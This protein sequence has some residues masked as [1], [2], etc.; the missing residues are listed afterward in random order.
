MNPL[1]ID[2][3]KEALPN[4]VN[5]VVNQQLVDRI[6]KTLTDP[7]MR[8]RYRE[9]LIS[10]ASVMRDGKFKVEGYL[11]A[12]MYVSYKLMDKTNVNAYSLTFP[13]KIARFAQQGVSTKDISSYVSAFANS[14]LVTLVM[15]QSLTPSWVVN[16]ALFQQALNKQAE[17]MNNPD[18]S[19][20]VQSDAANSILIHAKMPETQKVELDIGVKADSSIDELRKTT[21][22]LVAQ[23][24][25]ML[26][27]GVMN[28]KEVAHSNLLI[29][30]EVVDA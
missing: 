21:M 9:N 13:E 25:E 17:L 7:E 10:Y 18:V 2:Q 27:A 24:K 22:E 29:E 19:F 4:R 14:K 3:F 28:A 20:K 16:Q 26:K 30:G 23:Q 5:G 12:V 11:S 15:E 8:E 6:N 1:T